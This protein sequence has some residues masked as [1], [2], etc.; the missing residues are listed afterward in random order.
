MLTFFLFFFMSSLSFTSCEGFL[1]VLIWISAS[2]VFA[3]S[4]GKSILTLGLAEALEN[5]LDECLRIIRD[6]SA[7]FRIFA[8]IMKSV[9]TAAVVDDFGNLVGSLVFFSTVDG[10]DSVGD[11]P[12]ERNSILFNVLWK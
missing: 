10:W 1:L 4:A 9:F 6:A 2:S 3:C 12:Y 8:G 11:D 5:E 7:A